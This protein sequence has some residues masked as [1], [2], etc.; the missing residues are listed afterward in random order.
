M[1]DGRIVELFW[2][3]SEL[4]LEE[5]A[6]KYGKYCY[7]IAFNILGNP[8]D[9]DESV[10]DTYLG[11]WKSMPPHRPAV[12]S[13]FLGKITRRISLNRWRYQNRKKR[14]HGEVPLAMEELSWCLPSGENPEE[15]VVMQ[16]LVRGIDCFLSQ[17]P[18]T[19]RDVFMCRYWFFAP[20][21]EIG[22]RFGFTESKT[23]SILYRVRIK[24]KEYLRKE[25]YL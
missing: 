9:A 10:N 19:E 5:T 14:G 3:R 4:A 17:L 12:L 16:E 2:K 6:K 18:D 22:E 23:K 7:S 21:R 20:I 24:L 13:T 1:E 8:E 11:A 25:G 15:T